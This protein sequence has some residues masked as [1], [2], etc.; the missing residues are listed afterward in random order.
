MSEEPT[1]YRPSGQTIATFFAALALICSAAALAGWVFDFPALSSFGVRTRPPWPLTVL[2]YLA[3][4]LGFLAAIN[5]RLTPA[6]VGWGAT[7]C[8]AG[9]SLYQN[10]SGHD[11]GIDL[12]LFPKA[13]LAL[14]FPHPGRPGATP[15]TIFFLLAGAALIAANPRWQRNEPA[16]MIASGVLGLATAAGTLVIFATPDHSVAGQYRISLPSAVISLLLA[17]AFAFWQRGFRWVRLLRS[18][19]PNSRA[20]Q[21]LL[22]AALALPLIPSLVEVFIWQS[23]SM[24]PLGGRLVLMLLNI[25]LFGLIAYWFLRRVG[26]DQ[27]RLL[28]SIA[29]LGESEDRLV[30]ALAA[31]QLGVFEWNVAAGTLTWLPGSEKR[32][33]LEPGSMPTFEAWEELIEPEDFEA[34]MQAARKMVAERALRFH[35][36]YRFRRPLGHARVIEGSSR[37]FYD[38]EGTLLRTVGVV[39]NITEQVTREAELRAREA[40]L[41]SILETVPDAIIVLDQDGVILEFSAAAEALWGYPATGV[42]GRHFQML[43]PPAERARNE[44]FLKRYVSREAHPGET[45]VSV[46]SKNARGDHFP[47]EMRV[48]TVDVEKGMLL[49]V[50]VRD[51]TARLEAEARL[52]QLSSE[53]AHVSR[54]SAMSE[55]AADLAHELNQPLSATTNFLATAQILLERGDDV[56][57]A[58][59]MLDLASEQTLRAGEIIRRLRLF[60]ARGEVEVRQE[61]VEQTVRGAVA[62]IQVGAGQLR[63]SIDCDFDPAADFFLAD[64]IQIQ[65]VLVNLLR[66]SVDVLRN[67]ELRT[68]NI[69]VNSRRISGDF[70]EIEIADTGP[71]IPE[72]VLGTLFSRF[73]TTKN[74]GGGMGIG[75][76]ISRRIIEAHGGTISAQNLPEGGASF[77][78][79]VPVVPQSLAA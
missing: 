33:G 74:D 2:G 1:N 32:L 44:W 53:L 41:R 76:S 48:G 64:R 24:T 61:S 28:R 15:T 72:S 69:R 63:I 3:L 13:V 19:H 17:A 36:R 65:Q 66:N 73:T 18:P 30:T 57:R 62:L 7:L 77:R 50:F 38:N 56:A 27:E 59:E 55:L 11:L 39:T 75:L 5:G 37:A 29:A 20:L 67:Q 21:A 79:T 31:G 23:Q 47:I 43:A 6:R 51:I 14:G 54:L 16:R 35:Y 22:P 4:S 9:T 52:G 10:L 42:I 71:G 45:V 8:I 78:F 34:S 40:Q 12:L 46:M 68:R 25:M 70:V 58:R 49:T 26:R 60:M